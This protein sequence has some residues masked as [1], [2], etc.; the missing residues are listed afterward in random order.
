ML[1]RS[2]P[3]S[4]PSYLYGC[5][6]GPGGSVKM[7]IRHESS[8]NIFQGFSS[9]P[10]HFVS[11]TSIQPHEEP[12]ELFSDMSSLVNLHSPPRIRS[13][14]FFSPSPDPGANLETSLQTPS[15]SS[16]VI[17]S[18]DLVAEEQHLSDLIEETEEPSERRHH[19]SYS[20]VITQSA[21]VQKSYGDEKRFFTTPVCRMLGSG[22][23]VPELGVPKTREDGSSRTQIQVYLSTAEKD[24]APTGWSS[25][26]DAEQPSPVGTLDDRGGLLGSVS[27]LSER[28]DLLSATT[29]LRDLP[30]ACK[31]RRVAQALFSK[32]HIGDDEKRKT[33]PLSFKVRTYCYHIQKKGCQQRLYL[34]D[35]GANWRDAVGI[36]ALY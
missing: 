3:I 19:E 17:A 8:A 9:S 11:P 18:A 27:F 26:S 32:L 10:S 12:E 33:V 6:N 35:H 2:P 28:V 16:P 5:E 20:I 25:D 21:A 13:R 22:W 30:G 24:A 1:M 31:P 14:G 34:L 23:G 4:A 36:K 29:S 15:S 7:D